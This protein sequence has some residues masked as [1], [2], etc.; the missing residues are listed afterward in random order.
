MTS[1]FFQRALLVFVISFSFVFSKAQ[2]YKYEIGGM[3]G[4]AFYMGDANKNSLF[5]YMNPAAGAVIRYN[6]NFR[7][8]LK[9]S[10]VWGKVAGSTAN[11]ENVFPDQLQVSFEKN[12]VDLGGQIEFNFFPY[13]EKYTY[14]NTK[15]FTPYLFTGLGITTAFGE[16]NTSAGINLPVGVGAKYKLIN[17][18][19]LGCEFSFRKLF[20][21]NLDSAEDNSLLDNPY[22][23]NS[24]AFK[25]KD[26]YSFLLLSVTWD[27]GPRDRPCNNEESYY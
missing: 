9:G 3:A 8:A 22:K 15:R 17:R 18:V 19:N 27:F 10:L 23:M 4:G 26:W 5:K 11:T 6:A 2:E 21:D 14:A 1:T 12:L 16:G 20:G 24:S 13:S 25:N 7:W